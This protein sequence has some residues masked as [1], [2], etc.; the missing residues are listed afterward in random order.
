M[1]HLTLMFV[2]HS[3]NLRLVRYGV[4]VAGAP[5]SQLLI[6]DL[7]QQE[8]ANYS[9]VM[10]TPPGVEGYQVCGS[11][12]QPLLDQSLYFADNNGLNLEDNNNNKNNN[13]FNWNTLAP[14]LAAAWLTANPQLRNDQLTV[15]NNL[16]HSTGYTVLNN[17]LNDTR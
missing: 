3:G 9:T 2:W 7:S 12:C 17:D 11:E 4:Q 14:A 1:L 5:P 6:P 10:A 13:T 15:H 8:V 16:T